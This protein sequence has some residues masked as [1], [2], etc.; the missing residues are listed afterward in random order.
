MSSD[1]SHDPEQ[2]IS[3]AR[4]GGAESLG[5]LLDAS[6]GYLKLLARLQIDRRLQGKVDASDIVQET[7]MEANRA[8]GGFRGSTEGEFLTWLR[9]ILASRLAKAVRHFYGTQSRDVRLERQLGEELGRSSQAAQALALSQS[10]PSD[11]AVRREQAV[12]LADALER[13]PPHYRQAIILRQF[14]ELTFP[15]VALR[16]KRSVGSVQQ[17]WIRALTALRRSLGGGLS[18]AG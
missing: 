7:F 9:K 2:L 3:R 11:R 5:R 4:S 18:D 13:L 16:M 17:I 15:E 8:F 6:R 12:I 1:A 14:E 10:S